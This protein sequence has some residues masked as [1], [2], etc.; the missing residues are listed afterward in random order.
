MRRN[1]AGGSAES[2]GPTL[3]CHVLY[4]TKKAVR[5]NSKI[6]V[7]THPMEMRAL[8]GQ[9][10][11]FRGREASREVGAFNCRSSNISMELHQ[12][13]DAV[14]YDCSHEICNGCVFQI[15]NNLSLFCRSEDALRFTSGADGV[16]ERVDSYPTGQLSSRRHTG[17]YA[18]V[19][20][21]PREKR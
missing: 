10:S 21:P 15:P 8:M 13:G 3:S 20:I 16:T 4:L 6:A 18:V 5:Q 2:N 1:G 14:E 7:R 9:R 17:T 12:E 19:R 11:S